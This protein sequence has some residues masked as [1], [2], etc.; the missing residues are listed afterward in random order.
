[1]I[2]D[3]RSDTVTKPSPAMLAAMMRAEVGDD[4]FSEDPTITSLEALAAGMFGME[5]G[6]FCPSGTMTNQI[7]VKAHTQPLD[8]VICDKLCHIYNYEV[9]G[10]A[11]HSGVSVR[12]TDGDRG[13][14][15]CLLYTSDAADE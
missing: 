2:I 9:G 7:A 14:M 10:W 3:L 6:L 5:A 12:L 8:E 13:I 1:M 11:F 4:V 15:T